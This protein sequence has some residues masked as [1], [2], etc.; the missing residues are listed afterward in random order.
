[1]QLSRPGESSRLITDKKTFVPVPV[2]MN[3]SE[4]SRFE[5]GSRSET[6]WEIPIIDDIRK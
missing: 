4:L 5:K 2:V 3:Q 6:N 1:M